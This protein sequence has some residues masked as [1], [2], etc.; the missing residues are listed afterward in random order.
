[1]VVQFLVVALLL[2]PYLPNVFPLLALLGAISFF[3]LSA[4]YI[5]YSQHSRSI[6]SQSNVERIHSKSNVQHASVNGIH[7][8]KGFPRL[9]RLPNNSLSVSSRAS[10][11]LV[12]PASVVLSSDILRSEPTWT[13]EQELAKQIA[14]ATQSP[15]GFDTE[16]D[17]DKDQNADTSNDTLQSSVATFLF[18]ILHNE[19]F[20]PAIN[21]FPGIYSSSTVTSTLPPSTSTM[22]S[23]NSPMDAIIFQIA[24]R[25]TATLDS[26]A[27]LV[28]DCL[29]NRLKTDT[30]LKNE[31]TVRQFGISKNIPQFN[32]SQSILSKQKSSDQ[33][34]INPSDRSAFS[35]LFGSSQIEYVSNMASNTIN[36]M[37]INRLHE[38]LWI[39][40]LKVLQ[41]HVK[42]YRQIRRDIQAELT[43]SRTEPL[44][45]L[46]PSAPDPLS[47]ST[48]SGDTHGLFSDSIPHPK[49][50]KPRHLDD[51][52]AFLGDDMDDA[53]M[54][55][56][57]MD[58]LNEKICMRM[59]G[60]GNLHP[61]VGKGDFHEQS[62]LRST[63]DRVFE[64]LSRDSCTKS[65]LNKSPR[66]SSLSKSEDATKTQSSQM[67]YTDN[68]KYSSSKLMQIL[69]REVTVC[70]IV[71][72]FLNKFSQP[73]LISQILI[74]KAQRQIAFVKA[75]KTFRSQLDLCYTQFP[76][77]FL[78]P[79]RGCS[80]SFSVTTLG[81]KQR[82]FES[83]S[84]YS[85]KVR[86]LI[87]I[88]AVQHE[89]IRELKHVREEAHEQERDPRLYDQAEESRRY[90]KAL[91]VLKVKLDKKIA[92]LTALQ[93]ESTLHRTPKRIISIPIMGMMN[94]QEK[95]NQFENRIEISLQSI[96][97]EYANSAEDGRTTTSSS[98]YYFLDFLEKH[99]GGSGVIKLRFWFSAEKHR[100][101]I[102]RIG[103]G[104]GWKELPAAQSD[105]DIL[106]PVEA[107]P[108]IAHDRLRKDALR[109]FRTYLAPCPPTAAQI[110]VPQN[111]I[112]S[113]HRYLKPLLRSDMNDSFH[114][115]NDED[116]NCVTLAQ[117]TVQADLEKLFKA[118]LHSES[119]F[120]WLSERERAKVAQRDR[121]TDIALGPHNTSN[122]PTANLNVLNQSSVKNPSNPSASGLLPVNLGF[123]TAGGSVS[124]TR[125]LGAGLA[126]EMGGPFASVSKSA[127]GDLL[128]DTKLRNFYQSALMTALTYELDVAAAKLIVTKRAVQSGVIVTSKPDHVISNARTG[129]NAQSVFDMNA[130]DSDII[131][132]EEANIIDGGDLIDD[133][134]LGRGL[135][136]KEQDQDVD[137]PA[138]GEL[139]TSITKLQKIKD[140]IDKVMLQIDTI[141]MISWHINYLNQKN[142]DS[143]TNI[144]SN[145]EETADIPVS[146]RATVLNIL[147]HTKEILH[148]DIGE[149][150]RQ[151]AKYESQ[152][153]REAIVPGQCSINLQTVDEDS[154][155]PRD[156]S[157]SYLGGNALGF[158]SGALNASS[159]NMSTA[160]TG[161]YR[162]IYYLIQIE[163]IDQKTGWTVKRRYSDFDALHRKLKETFPIVADFDFPGKHHLGVFSLS[164]KQ[165]E[166]RRNARMIALQR[167]LRRLIDNPSICQ[168]DY[169][170]DFLSS[171]YQSVRRKGLFRS[172]V[173]ST[174]TGPQ[175]YSAPAQNLLRRKSRNVAMA[176]AQLASKP[177][178][179]I[180]SEGNDSLS[181]S[182]GL[183]V[184][185]DTTAGSVSAVNPFVQGTSS[186]TAVNSS[187]KVHL[188]SF[189]NGSRHRK[190]GK[191][192]AS[193]AKA[194]VNRFGEN[195][196]A[197]DGDGDDFNDE[198]SFGTDEAEASDG[199]VDVDDDADTNSSVRAFVSRSPS[200]KYND[201]CLLNSNGV[202][203][204]KF[205]SDSSDDSN[206]EDTWAGGHLPDL[207]SDDVS[208]LDDPNDPILSNSFVQ[209]LIDPLC[210]LLME[211]FDF[212]EQN[213]W[214]RRST[215]SMLLME[216]MGGTN[217]SEFNDRRISI[218]LMNMLKGNSISWFLETLF[219]P[220]NPQTGLST[221]APASFRS[222]VPFYKY[223]VGGVPY[224]SPSRQ[225]SIRIEAKTKIIQAIPEVFFRV[226]GADIATQGAIRCFEMLQSVTLNK[227]LMYKLLDVFLDTIVSEYG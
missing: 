21:M 50:T 33:C 190:W 128:D 115:A 59:S 209:P 127:A 4:G 166:A 87:D 213:H 156:D 76:P 82:L 132:L 44:T 147:D 63:F 77:K 97:D 90:I 206:N 14:A 34:P 202:D 126:G 75:A 205:T 120:R 111:V 180:K 192:G 64:I 121:G 29:E 197:D 107:I 123:T 227:S 154:T 146:H 56:K 158:G 27:Q 91:E 85:R 214:L 25:A 45:G 193:A 99:D 188:A 129:I 36:H 204:S 212:K 110:Q 54:Y 31:P 184:P 23:G 9:V 151:K 12:Q 145:D 159:T 106:E 96:L 78:L 140:D 162:V 24:N 142:A 130:L 1:M 191:D 86:S 122:H 155:D 199:V 181:N 220:T 163:R 133:S 40:F 116:Y 2:S 169:L 208:G 88:K 207:L 74:D 26:S 5:M 61:A 223:L 143:Q 30:A 153:Q 71:W 218:L 89:I 62:Y 73:H 15:L 113:F 38:R 65:S 20:E 103:S 53:L 226:L 175:N 189:F 164:N 39:L 118:F 93:G 170:R 224:I 177:L 222:T 3:L 48:K 55:N 32:P 8:K 92:A 200:T 124:G 178:K 57:N 43:A 221:P 95:P 135:T 58:S 139:L 141:D 94:K 186:T 194:T 11:P 149:L 136:V 172:H 176:L 217:A 101:T 185:L 219:S 17:A 167:Y 225:H 46:K 100:R 182:S 160:A 6:N 69:M 215:A 152:E 148:L 41:K 19:L 28:P 70:Q 137:L 80:A 47:E 125:E 18:Y 72:P 144:D 211:A 174:K 42:E 98:I 52:N 104:L 173:E 131:T 157:R 210:A 66:S 187:R 112:E 119:Y 84:K 10:A 161:S 49:I 196:D 171:T 108:S 60:L 203:V 114:E 16:L 79:G 13:A 134:E 35:K 22:H 168:S 102:W 201:S 68:A 117:Q 150:S 105:F 37:R 51:F 67:P 165:E 198:D 183:T 195:K 109:I 83:L 179:A 7:L 216:V 81:E 138:P